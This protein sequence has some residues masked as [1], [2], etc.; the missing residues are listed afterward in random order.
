MVL[1]FTLDGPYA[2]YCQ[3]RKK[4]CIQLLSAHEFLHAIGFL[5]EQ[6]RDDAP[7]ECKE[8]FGHSADI[9]G[10]DPEPFSPAYDAN[11]LMNYCESIFR[12][13]VA[14]SEADVAAVNHFYRLQ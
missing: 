3:S 9:L 8:R 5:H 7:P 2:S 4:H 1:N 13:P 14:L 12:E 10:E 11:S 6:L